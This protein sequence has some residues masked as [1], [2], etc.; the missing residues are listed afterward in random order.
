M[1]DL[2]DLEKTLQELKEKYEPCDHDPAYNIE[3]LETL[4][5]DIDKI[6][7]KF[8][9]KNTYVVVEKQKLNVWIEKYH[10]YGFQAKKDLKE[11]LTEKKET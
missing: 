11:L 9:F 7:E 8:V 2:E 4:Q 1:S 5:K 6:L 3:L 10:H